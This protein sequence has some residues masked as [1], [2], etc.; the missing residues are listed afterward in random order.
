[1]ILAKIYNDNDD[2]FG[3]KTFQRSRMLDLFLGDW[4]RHGDQYRWVDELQ[5]KNK[6]YRVVPRDRDQV[7]RLMEGILPYFV[8][9][10]WAV[11]TI[12]GFGPKIKDV[13]YS[14]FKSDFLNAQPEMQLNLK[15]W[16]ALSN[17]FVANVT[18]SV[19]VESIKSL[20][21]SSYEIRHA[22][23]LADLKERRDAIP[24]EMEKHYRFINS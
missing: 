10:S 18:D 19:L 14:L 2:T 21:L 11:P 13:D 20:P 24:A 5:G 15:D 1:K 6:D 16:N 9:R 7:L 17:E 3:T 12:Q 22:E 23:L 8:S 4:D